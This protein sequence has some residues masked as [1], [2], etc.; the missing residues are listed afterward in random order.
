MSVQ[1]DKTSAKIL[2]LGNS[3]VGKSSLIHLICHS[4]NSTSA[5]QID[6]CWIDIKLFGEYFLELWEIGGSL[7]YGVATSFL[8]Q[9]YHGIMLVFDATNKK[10]K[11]NLNEWLVEVARKSNNSNENLLNYIPTIKIGTKKDQLPYRTLREIENESCLVKEDTNSS[12]VNF[13]LR[14]SRPAPPTTTTTTTNYPYRRLRI[15]EDNDSSFLS[16]LNTSSRSATS[17]STSVISSS[18]ISERYQQQQ[19]HQS[20]IY[21]NTQEVQSFSAGSRNCEELENF[22]KAVIER[23]RRFHNKFAI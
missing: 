1:L 9:D 7:N 23:R 6:G 3:G 21:V 22:F 15:P 5:P 16:S 10:S 12:V 13:D 17:S 11:T 2:V 20:V 14:S 8:Y 18:N 19:Q 4:T